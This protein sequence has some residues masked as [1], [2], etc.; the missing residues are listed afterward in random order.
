MRLIN[1]ELDVKDD[2]GFEGGINIEFKRLEGGIDPHG[3]VIERENGI[4]QAAL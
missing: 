2:I 3:I 1:G 4:G